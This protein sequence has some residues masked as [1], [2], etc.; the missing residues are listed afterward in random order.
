MHTLQR[1]WTLSMRAQNYTDGY[2]FHLLDGHKLPVRGMDA[3]PIAGRNI[4]QTFTI[5]A[6]E[7]TRY[8]FCV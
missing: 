2:E 7:L 4:N 3:A 5:R 6:Y 8:R 1:Q